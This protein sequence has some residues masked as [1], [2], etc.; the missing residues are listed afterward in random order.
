MHAHMRDQEPEKEAEMAE[1]MSRKMDTVVVQ[2]EVR[3]DL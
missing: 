1:E 2:D 3:A